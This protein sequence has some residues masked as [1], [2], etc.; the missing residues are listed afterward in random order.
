MTAAL[1]LALGI[2]ACAAPASTLVGPRWRAL[3]RTGLL[4]A[5]LAIG[6]VLCLHLGLGIPSGLLLLVVPLVW[7]AWA[8]VAPGPWN[9]LGR[10]LM[11]L[12]A[13]GLCVALGEP[14]TGRIAVPAAAGGV[15]LLLSGPANEAVTVLLEL[16]RGSR[17]ARR[18]APDGSC[19][20]AGRGGAGAV[21]QGSLLRPAAMRGGRWIG[22]LERIL[23]VLLV[24]TGAT[25]AVA[26][27]VAAKGVIRFPEINKDEDG[28]KAEEF[29]VGSLASWMLAAIGVVLMRSA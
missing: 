25:E 7:G 16:A 15:L 26:A 27:V 24:A 28:R 13:L 23:I 29:L 17:G 22:P 8:A 20:E 12:A 21:G 5:A 19:G 18:A 6:A 10:W 2:A 4:V 9:V 11:G 14:A 3:V 1:T